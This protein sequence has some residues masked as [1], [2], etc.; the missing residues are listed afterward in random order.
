MASSAPYTLPPSL[1][2]EPLYAPPCP[3]TAAALFDAALVLQNE[4]RFAAAINA[5]LEAQQAW[6]TALLEE[7]YPD[8]E[9]RVAHSILLRLRQNE[10]RELELAEAERVLAEE[11]ERRRLEG[12]GEDED[13]DDFD[14]DEGEL[15][16]Q[17][18][19]LNNETDEDAQARLAGQRRQKQRG[20]AAQKAQ[21][22]QQGKTGG[23]SPAAAT[24]QPPS[25]VDDDAVPDPN[26]IFLEQQQ[27]KLQQA[28]AE[29]ARIKAE[30]EE[31]A[32][33]AFD[34]ERA[35]KRREKVEAIHR[36]YQLLP[37]E[38]KM[39]IQLR[40][41]SIYESAGDD[42]RALATALYALKFIQTL[43]SFSEHP[44]T[45]T[46]YAAIGVIYAHIGQNDYASDYFFRALE[47]REA[48]LGEG[49]VDT[50]TTMHNIGCIL[51][52]L[53]K[54][55]DALVCYYKSLEVLR[56]LLPASHPRIEMCEANIRKSKEM[57]FKGL[58]V[59][60]VLPVVAAK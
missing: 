39:F 16:R 8:I 32:R 23:P 51:H 9:D 26:A 24:P 14:D 7:H 54:P 25:T 10:K 12:E 19:A 40:L 35:R 31:A 2:R 30:E 44:I 56:R 45:A 42:E 33:I 57:Q 3:P 6:E 50:A 18:E 46:I 37:L 20:N 47:I 49:H 21:Q 28:Q 41:S 52:T 22:Q 53:E 5:T 4:G 48:L 13:D 60:P 43:P 27:Q 59:P 36:V 38:G 11:E 34:K 15:L 29:A 55:N 1:I 17:M 58:K